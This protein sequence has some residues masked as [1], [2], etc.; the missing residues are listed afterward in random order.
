MQTLKR[1]SIVLPVCVAL[2]TGTGCG[3]GSN[4]PSAVDTG[5]LQP[6]NYPTDPRSAEDVRTPE[7]IDIQEALRLGASVPMIMESE[8]RF[9]FNQ[10]GS[11][12]RKIITQKNPPIYTEFDF[13]AQVPGFIAG[14]KTVGQ[15]REN[16]VHG[17]V[18]ELTVLRF[19]EPQ[20]AEHAAKYLSDA[21][22]RG[23]YPPIGP[24]TVPG[25]PG[26]FGQVS[27]YGGIS[28][29]VAQGSF[30]V[31][32]WVGSGVD[33]PPDPAAL[34]ELFKHVLDRQFSALQSYEP[35]PPDRIDELPVDRDGLLQYTL[36]GPEPT[37][38]AVVDPD[39][40]L[41]FLQRPDLAKRAFEDAHV[42]LT[43]F[44]ATTI[45]RAGDPAAADRLKAFFVSQQD[46]ALQPVDSPPGLPAAACPWP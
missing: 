26:A 29:W 31:Q 45:Y 12:V 37:A 7:N 43:V 23:K 2:L 13:S 44:G 41:N 33:I 4:S 6:G 39:V 38:E 30:M 24:I 1:L 16:S 40:A 9:V 28:V 32:A 10:V 46:S 5:A 8:P 22:L 20:Q 34:A 25:Y 35:T 18:V 36:V 19:A 42:D 17:R 27:K 11:S 21:N 3:D 15:R 14:W